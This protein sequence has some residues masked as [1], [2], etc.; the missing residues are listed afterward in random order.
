MRIRTQALLRA[1]AIVALAIPDGM[2]HAA[3]IQ[4]PNQNGFSVPTSLRIVARGPSGEPLEL[5]SAA[6][7]LTVWNGGDLISLPRDGSAAVLKLDQAW[8]CEAANDTCTLS[9]FEG[10]R[11]ILKV[12]GYAPVS[13]NVSWPGPSKRSGAP[14]TPAA[15]V[16]FSNN[17]RIHLEEGNL[18]Q[19]AVPFR[20]PEKRSIRVV[21]D[22]GNATPGVRLH[23]HIF[24]NHENHL[25]VINGELLSEGETRAD[26]TFEFPDVDGEVAFGFDGGHYELLPPGRA[27]IGEFIFTPAA[28]IT[29]IKIHKFE[30]HPLNLQINGVMANTPGFKLQVYA[31]NCRCSG[32]AQDI[33]A[34]ESHGRYYFEDFYPEEFDLIGIANAAGLTVWWGDPDS[35]ARPTVQT[36]TLPDDAIAVYALIDKMELEPVGGTSERVRIRGTFSTVRHDGH[37]SP[38]SGY[39]YF[40]L[41]DGLESKYKDAAKREWTELNSYAGTNTAVG[42]GLRGLDDPNRFGPPPRIHKILAPAPAYPEG[43]PAGAGVTRLDPQTHGD[44]IRELRNAGLK[45]VTLTRQP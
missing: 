10:S 29:T 22:R 43:Y 4:N 30:K 1:A 9:S 44:I 5:K 8:L 18:K 15:N 14:A 42:F 13:A 17:L 33:P 40:E 7:F 19:I 35:V 36:V 25:A 16:E 24:Y 31:K 39:L 28:A 12:D 37:T 3:A 20:R 2:D 45:E 34:I 26:G 21:D 41:P 11:L 27:D 6:M 38:Q 23:S 32:F